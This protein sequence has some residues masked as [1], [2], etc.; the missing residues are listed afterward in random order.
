MCDF[1]CIIPS[2]V[3]NHSYL[4]WIYSQQ[5]DKLNCEYLLFLVSVLFF[6]SG[7]GFSM[8]ANQTLP[9]SHISSLDR[10]LISLTLVISLHITVTL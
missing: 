2:C 6:F 8:Y 9:S 1:L 5:T 3:V 7:G 10:D 4:L